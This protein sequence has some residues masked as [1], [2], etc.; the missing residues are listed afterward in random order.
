M[1]FLLP[2]GYFFILNFCGA[3]RCKSGSTNNN[4]LFS[5]F[6]CPTQ[7]YLKTL[8]PPIEVH[9]KT[10]VNHTFGIMTYGEII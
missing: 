1:L 6:L 9:D 3:K 8:Q 5:S 10:K 7:T 4:E 2:N